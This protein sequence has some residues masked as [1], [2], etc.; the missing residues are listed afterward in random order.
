MNLNV[1]LRDFGLTQKERLFVAWNIIYDY[2]K[3][4]ETF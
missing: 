1:C 2:F 4:V 3:E